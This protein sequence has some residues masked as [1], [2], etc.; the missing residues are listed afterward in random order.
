VTDV[1]VELL[2]AA[3]VLAVFAAMAYGA[4]IVQAL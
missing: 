4:K 1:L 2:K 3:G